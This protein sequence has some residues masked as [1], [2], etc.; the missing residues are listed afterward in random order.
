MAASVRDL[1]RESKVLE[2]TLR[3]HE[4]TALD[5]LEGRMDAWAAFTAIDESCSKTAWKL[6]PKRPSCSGSNSATRWI[7]SWGRR[8]NS[9]RLLMER[10]DDL[11]VAVETRLLE[12]WRCLLAESW[13]TPLPWWLDG[14]L[15]A[16]HRTNIDKAVATMPS[17]A[18][19]RRRMARAFIDL[20]GQCLNATGSAEPV[21]ALAASVQCPL[22]LSSESVRLNAAV[23]RAEGDDR[24][25]ISFDLASDRQP[26]ECRIFLS[27]PEVADNYTTVRFTWAESPPQESQIV[28]GYGS[29]PLAPAARDTLTDASSGFVGIELTTENGLIRPVLLSETTR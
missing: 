12:N 27:P 2:T 18:E 5:L 11:A 17:P 6:L 29:I 26:E 22:F 4:E 14:T 3:E 19:W 13:R 24:L 7:C 15:E 10:V 23:F 1:D 20:A 25:H 9:D 16:A 21:Y 8:R 28:A